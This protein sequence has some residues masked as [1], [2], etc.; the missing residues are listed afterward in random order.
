Q[1]LFARVEEMIDE[2]GFDAQVPR[3]HV[4]NEPFRERRLVA[5]QLMHRGLLDD[6]QCRRRGRGGRPDANRLTRERTFPEEVTRTQHGHHGFLA[7]PG[8]HRDL[9]AALLDVHDGVARL[10]LREDGLPLR[11]RHDA[12][13]RTSG[14]EE[15]LGV[16][17]RWLPAWPHAP[18]FG[19]GHWARA[20][21]LTR[22]AGNRSVPSR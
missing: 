14:L 9:D 21:Y 8:E 1:P 4:R 7:S 3:Q 12:P 17:R 2:V 16:E 20:N 6:Q 11:V 13:R 19:S 18:G 22:L 5:Q 10:T 15:R